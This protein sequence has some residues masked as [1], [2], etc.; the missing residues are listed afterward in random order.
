MSDAV[1]F[2]RERF[3]RHLALAEVG[4]DGQARLAQATMLIVG[5]GGLGCPAAQ[6]LASSGVG[7]LLL[8]DFDR[9]DR[10]NLPRQILY[11]DND[12]GLRKVDAAAASLA[13]LNPAVAVEAVPERLNE[14]ALAELVARADIVLDCTDNFTT[15]LA[16]N[17]AVVANGRPLVSGAALRFEGQLAVFENGPGE[18]CYR[19]L[20]SED[21]ELLG[22]CE[23]NGVLAPVPGVI[24]TLMAVEALQLALTGHSPRN[25]VL[26]IWDALSGGW[27]SIRLAR[28]PAC[29]VCG[30]DISSGLA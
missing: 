14:P 24:G 13:R 6:Y 20:Y 26:G 30:P 27:Q 21:D 12:V 9:V 25:G 19:C 18:P 15:R 7:R 4:V 8:N 3:A 10:S 1:T 28:D 2:D 11:S 22:N 17:R 16:I 29:P 5:L 23:G